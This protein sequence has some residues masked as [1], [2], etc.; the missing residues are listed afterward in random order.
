MKISSKTEKNAGSM[1]RSEIRLSVCQIRAPQTADA[2]SKDG[3][4]E[5]NDAASRRKTKGD[6][7]SASTNTIPH[8]E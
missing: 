3:S 1:S 4:M 6:Q 2:S 8:I 7:S 5:R